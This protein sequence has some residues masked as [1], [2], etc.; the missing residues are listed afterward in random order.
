MIRNIVLKK[1]QYITSKRAIHIIDDNKE[2]KTLYSKKFSYRRYFL[3]VLLFGMVFYIYCSTMYSHHRNHVIVNDKNT[4][5]LVINTFKRYDMLDSALSYYSLCPL[6]KQIYVIWNEEKLPPSLTVKFAHIKTPTIQYIMHNSDSLNNRFK[7]IKG[8]HTDGI[9]TV[10]DDMRI[11]CSDLALAHEVW[12]NNQQS[13][14]GF[15]PRIHL[16]GKDGQLN[17]RC[18][19]RVWWDGTYSI[20][21]TKAAFIHHKYLELYTNNMPKGVHELVDKERNC[22][23]IA[24]QFLIANI[25][26]LPPVYVKGHLEDLGALNGIS[27][28]KNVVKAGHMDKRSQCLNDLE[29]IFGHLPLVNSHTIV[30]S[31]SNVWSNSP[32]TFWEFISSDLWRW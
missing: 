3:Y 5:T 31:A 21:L 32:S 29:K 28:S 23:D 10:D 18:W 22:E 25:S 20:I 15:M 30:D 13:I 6:V 26:S 12:R 14:V 17:Y 19:W 2:M 9:F 24:M 27:T 7:P 16:R 1:P 11:P 4:F 8:P